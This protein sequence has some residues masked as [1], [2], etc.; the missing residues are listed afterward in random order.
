M[1]VL[2]KYNELW[3][4]EA[5]F[6]VT[7]HDLKVRPVYHW[8]PGRVAAHIAICFAAYSLV[9][10]L[11]YRVRLQYKKLSIE[12]I[13]QLLMKVQ[14]SILFDSHKRI[15]YGL[16]SRMKRDARKIYNILDIKRS[17]TPYIIEKCKL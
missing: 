4:V 10:N 11:Q 1:D 14:T 17:I 3:N 9:K 5:A 2:S 8:K 6:R 13:R 15:R 16:P 12:K 7:K